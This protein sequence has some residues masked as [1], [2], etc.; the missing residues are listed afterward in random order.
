M[1]EGSG[2]VFAIIG[3]AMTVFCNVEDKMFECIKKHKQW[4][5]ISAI[6]FLGL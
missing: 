5:I 4:I 6:A 2:R 1:R 3:K